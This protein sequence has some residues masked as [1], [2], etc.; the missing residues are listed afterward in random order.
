M[1]EKEVKVCVVPKLKG[2]VLKCKTLLPRE[3]SCPLVNGWRVGCLF[4]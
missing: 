4:Y 2:L 3:K 1:T